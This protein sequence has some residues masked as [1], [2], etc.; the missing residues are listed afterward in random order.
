MRKVQ[1]RHCEGGS[2]TGKI[3]EVVKSDRVWMRVE[4]GRMRTE[5]LGGNLTQEGKMSGWSREGHK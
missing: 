1:G 5:R 2:R 3:K 4:E